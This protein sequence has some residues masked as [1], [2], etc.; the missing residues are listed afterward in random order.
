MTDPE[1]RGLKV[2]EHFATLFDAVSVAVTDPENRGLKVLAPC[3]KA[4]AIRRVAVTDPENRGL[5]D[6][7]CF[8]FQVDNLTLQ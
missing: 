6:L 3:A 4:H 7:L 2:Q 5:K 8:V 1:N